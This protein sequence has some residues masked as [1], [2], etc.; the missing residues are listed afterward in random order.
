MPYNAFTNVCYN[1]V[2]EESIPKHITC[3]RY[4]SICTECTCE[5]CNGSGYVRNI[6]R[7]KPMPEIRGY[8]PCRCDRIA[9]SR[10]R[11]SQM[12]LGATVS[13]YKLETY[14]ADN[15][16]T[17]K[18]KTAAESYI[19]KGF[20]GKRSFFISGR[21]GS[22]KSHICVGITQEVMT[23]GDGHTVE[24]FSWIE[25]SG[26]LKRNAV[27]DDGY[28]KIL[29]PALKADLLYIDDFFKNYPNDADK[30]IAMEIIGGRYNSGK[31]CVI[32]SERSLDDIAKIDEALSGRISEMCGNYVLTSPNIDRRIKHKTNS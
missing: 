26:E 15:D 4:G 24:F 3:G 7:S 1:I 27:N 28:S 5:S 20:T 30:K 13:R 23:L 10:Y 16:N 6:D 18:I 9:L 32:S 22:G 29:A 25:K 8:K 19:S 14:K 31:P 11:L 12:G 21:P 17:K 2:P